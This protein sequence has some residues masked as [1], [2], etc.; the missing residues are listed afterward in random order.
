MQAAVNTFT[1]MP[2][3]SELVRTL[4]A[5]TLS[6]DSGGPSAQDQSVGAIADVI[7]TALEHLPVFKAALPVASC[8]TLQEG[9]VQKLEA[10]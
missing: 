6:Q 1:L 10:I 9:I 7:A 4:E 2:Q 3:M 5:A 8:M